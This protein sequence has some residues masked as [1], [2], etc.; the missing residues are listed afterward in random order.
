MRKKLVHLHVLFYLLTVLF[1]Y[2]VTHA[3]SATSTA[4]S[5]SAEVKAV[6]IADVSVRNLQILETSDKAI[7]IKFD[8]VNKGVAVDGFSYGLELLSNGVVAD[9][10]SIGES[11]SLA[12]GETKTV[13]VNYDFPAIP[14]GV[15]SLTLR[16]SMAS[17]MPLASKLVSNI[18]IPKQA[19]FGIKPESCVL[20]VSGE[21]ASKTYTTN[22]GVDVLSSEKLIASCIVVNN[23]SRSV[24]LTPVLETFLRNRF[25]VKVDQK[26][27]VD[28]T[29]TVASGAQKMVSVQIAVP[30]KGQ[31]YD[32]LVSF[33]DLGM[34]SNAVAFHYVVRGISATLQSISLDKT[35]YMP[36]E[37]AQ[38]SI[39]WTSSADSFPD[40][41]LGAGTALRMPSAVA[42]LTSNGT[43]CATD[44]GRVL[45]NPNE[46]IYLDIQSEC[47]N[48]K[49]E[50]SIKNGAQILAKSEYQV[51]APMVQAT[52]TEINMTNIQLQIM[53]VALSLIFAFVAF[54]L[55]KRKKI[56]VAVV[57]FFIVA[58]SLGA[59]SAEAATVSWTD[60]GNV[61]HQATVDMT[62]DTYDQ[63]EAVEMDVNFDS[64]YQWCTNGAK[65]P[66]YF[67]YTV[68]DGEGHLVASS[69][70]SQVSGRV[71]AYNPGA[72]GPLA[73]G[74]YYVK[75]VFGASIMTPDQFTQGTCEIQ[76]M[77]QTCLMNNQGNYYFDEQDCM[78]TRTESCQ[79]PTHWALTD[80]GSYGTI[81]LSF[82]VT[83]SGPTNTEYAPIGVFD[84]ADCN[85]I[86]GWALDGDAQ[87]VPTD[88]HIYKNGPA[89]SGTIIGAWSAN[90]PR[91]DV[92][93]ALNVRGDHGWSFATPDSL[94]TGQDIPLYV[95][96]LGKDDNGNNNGNNALLNNSPKTLN[97]APPVN[98]PQLCTDSA[99]INYNGS[100][101]CSYP[102]AGSTCPDP[103]ANN[104]GAVGQCTYSLCT[105]A[106]ALNYNGNL[107]CLY[108]PIV[109]P[110]VV[111][112][113][114][115]NN[116]GGGNGGPSCPS[117]QLLVGGACVTPGFT[118]S[119]TPGTVKV[120]SVAGYA[121]ATEETINL[122]VNP[123]YFSA[124]VS[125]E[126]SAVPGELQPEFSFNGNNFTSSLSIPFTLN[127]GGLEYIPVRVRFGQ[128]LS[129]TGV[130]SITFR[131]TGVDS[132]VGTLTQTATVN[133]DSRPLYPGFIE[134]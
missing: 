55:L 112:G 44:V 6:V 46:V 10:K 81:D 132:R 85:V 110:P 116:G 45:S 108:N 91:P 27:L 82:N 31:A 63:G 107:P 83:G 86:N 41:R 20:R 36:G 8:F 121:G 130:Y 28:N 56:P 96:V 84:N 92:N 99:A 65:R 59:L 7:K 104:F 30:E 78:V 128:K 68:R 71:T 127:S 119:A 60:K 34:R 26:A 74:T 134:F 80:Q 133:L 40:S 73:N 25:G 37:D 120:K 90:Q 70:P 47:S 131:A 124:P 111:T 11:A 61:Q 129:E 29:V 72:S 1:S 89:G 64:Q 101:P 39:R 75:T 103:T 122:F 117:N 24:T 17:G 95:Y 5:T 52:T 32:T 35:S 23:L 2:Q 77:D 109:E 67:G 4:T 53:V 42:H 43:L 66:V 48:P 106:S 51:E 69:E 93:S 54:C 12:V 22:E 76:E 19:I 125:L 87:D 114:G 58:G 118:L 16:A 13:E 100:L 97:C 21:P 62:K 94:K 115:G 57:A 38:V 126:V 50:V 88:I 15:Y 49:L 18:E 102:P 98:P 79:I 9:F 14:S 105:D 33:T 113:G 123:F 3:Q